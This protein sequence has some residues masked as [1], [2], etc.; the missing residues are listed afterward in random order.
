MSELHFKLATRKSSANSLSQKSR[1]NLDLERTKSSVTTKITTLNGKNELKDPVLLKGFEKA[2]KDS[3]R[4]GNLEKRLDRIKSGY[5]ANKYG[6]LQTRLND[7]ESK[8]EYL[9]KIIAQLQSKNRAVTSGY[10]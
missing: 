8:N 7:A 4:E 1:S 3:S 9:S 2:M 5:D 6:E 10:K